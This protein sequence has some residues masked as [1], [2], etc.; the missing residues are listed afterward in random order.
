MIDYFFDSYALIEIIEGNI[1]YN[2]YK[3]CSFIFTGLNLAEVYYSFLLRNE[4][5][6]IMILKSYKDNIVEFSVDIIEKAM[7][8]RLKNKKMNLSYADCIGYIYSCE[9][10]LK[11]LTGDEKFK[12]MKNV[13]FVKK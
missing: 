3:N 4:S 10:N 11:F 7:K 1:K 9:N 8:F 12:N 6:A 13:E 2:D 5:K